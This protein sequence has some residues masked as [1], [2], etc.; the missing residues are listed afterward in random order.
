MSQHGGRIPAHK[1]RQRAVIAGAVVAALGVGVGLWAT[2]GDGGGDGDREGSAAR[3][4]TGE[5]AAPSP[6]RS[7]PLSKAPRTIPAVR[8]HT[9]AR[10][11]GWQ[12]EKGNRVVVADSGLADEGKQI[13]GDLGMTYAGE[14]DDERAGD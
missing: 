13:A 2:D 9:A 3:S 7:Y 12:P 4:S 5:A 1:V 11:P 6:S 14:K 8:E 10:G